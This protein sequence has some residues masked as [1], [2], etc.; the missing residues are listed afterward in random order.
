MPNKL[1]E[2]MAAGLPVIASNFPLWSKIVEGNKCDITVDPLNSTAIGQAIE[3]LLAH[4]ELRQEM[5]NHGRHAV[6]VK[7][8]WNS[9]AET[10]LKF[11]K[12]LG[13]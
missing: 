9:E 7:Y 13:R 8:N 11:Y 4:P 1:F 12:H 3:F 6:D 5:G 10:L 2:Y